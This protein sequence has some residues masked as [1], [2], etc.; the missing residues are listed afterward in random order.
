MSQANP[1]KKEATLRKYQEK[2]AELEQQI[3][4]L[5]ATPGDEKKLEDLKA[6]MEELRAH[7]ERIRDEDVTE[8]VLDELDSKYIALHGSV[9]AYGGS[10]TSHM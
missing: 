1:V 6:D 2:I 5:E 10:T 9:V 3:D 4:R 8:E 7:Y